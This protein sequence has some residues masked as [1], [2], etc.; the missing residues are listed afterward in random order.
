MAVGVAVCRG[1]AAV[2]G[3]PSIPISVRYSAG[4][5]AVAYLFVW[6]ELSRIRR[7]IPARQVLLGV[8]DLAVVMALGALSV[9][10]LPYAHVL[11]FFGAARLAARFR[12]PRILAAGLLLFWPFEA[13]GPPPPLAILIALSPAPMPMWLPLYPTSP[14]P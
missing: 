14:P 9:G 2:V 6:V 11:I 13:P 4:L 7:P 10:Y 5:A 3:V 8:A 1:G 12:D